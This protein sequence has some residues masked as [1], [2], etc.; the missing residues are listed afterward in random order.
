[1]KVRLGEWNVR[2]QTERLP[3]EDFGLEAKYVH[4]A[5][6][7]ADFRNDVALVRLERDVVFKV[8]YIL[9]MGHANIIEKQGLRLRFNDLI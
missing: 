7:P 4:P 9:I 1:M 5:Y 8:N 6:S 2:E 3:H